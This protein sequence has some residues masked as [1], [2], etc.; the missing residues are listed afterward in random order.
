MTHPKEPDMVAGALD[1]VVV[2]DMTGGVEQYCS[3]MLAQMGAAVILVEP[4]TGAT[5]RREGPFVG[6]VPHRENSLQF[7]Y[8]NQGKRGVCVDLDSAD[9]QAV[10]RS[11]VADA[12]IVIDA[13]PLELAKSR[14]L[15][16]ETLR[17]AHPRL[18]TVNITPF[19][20]TGPYADYG[21]DD[22]V[23]LAAGG[24]LYLGGYPGRAPTAPYGNQAV[25][26][27][28]QFAAV[29]S[30]VALLEREGQAGTSEGQHIDVSVQECVAMALENAVQF[31]DLEGI[32]RTRNAGDQ[33]QAGT[34]AFEC[35][36]GLVYLMAAGVGSSRFWE[37]TV[38]WLIDEKIEGADQ[39]R[40][41]EWRDPLYLQT[42]EAKRRFAGCF[43]PLSSRNTKAALYAEG[44]RRRVPISPI[45]TPADLL[46]NRQLLHRNYF[47]TVMHPHSGAALKTPGAP[48]T[49]EQTPWRIGGP[50]PS[51]GEHTHAVLSELGYGVQEQEVLLRAGAIA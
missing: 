11:L 15:D 46:E 38:Q 20:E 36:D 39:L 16:H 45:N 30:M 19:G 49:F 2:V 3:K 5:L 44:Q 18:L 13:T 43:T 26:A 14:G 22:L 1:G 35:S 4:I 47:Q 27:A 41:E 34:G 28:A 10:M 7:A 17:A 32:V 33:R 23:A 21:G 40:G 42:E 25:L 31:V 12:D 50:A 9:G 6:D 29:A 48:Y 24:L 8:F 37:A 51:L